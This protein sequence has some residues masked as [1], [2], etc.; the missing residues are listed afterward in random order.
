MLL[1]ANSSNISYKKLGTQTYVCTGDVICNLLLKSNYMCNLHF[2]SNYIC[3]LH[4]HSNCICNLQHISEI[5]PCVKA[6]LLRR[7]EGSSRAAF[8]K[9]TGGQCYDHHFDQ[10][11]VKQ[12]AVFLDNTN[13]TAFSCQDCRNVGHM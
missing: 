10:F 11:S 3:N 13:V 2:H 4:L 7:E 8:V 12:S 9:E 6:F 5:G 1:L